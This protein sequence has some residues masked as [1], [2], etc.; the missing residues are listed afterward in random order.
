MRQHKPADAL[1]QFRI[2]LLAQQRA[3]RLL[4]NGPAR[5]E[6]KHGNQR[7]DPA[8]NPPVKEMPRQAA[9]QHRRG[10]DH[11]VPAVCGRGLQ[12]RGV[13]PFAQLSAK[14]AHP[15]LHK[16]GADED[17]EGQY[18]EFHRFGMENLLNGGFS[19]LH[20]DDQNQDC[21]KK[22]G[23]V[24]HSRMT[25]GMLRVCGTL[26]HFEAQQRDQRG[27]RIGEVVYGVGRNGDGAG[28]GARQQ[29]SRKKQE[30]ADDAHNPSQFPAGAPHRRILR[31]LII[32]DKQP[33]QELRHSRSLLSHLQFII[34]TFAAKVHL[35]FRCLFHVPKS[36]GRM[37]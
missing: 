4:C 14:Q 34:Q 7:A 23:E 6:D 18:G 10:C 13:N 3:D 17:A 28:E 20:A 12:R 33:Q 16:D 15:Q 8:V 1:H 37:I 30:I 36:C 22:A 11:V 21:H 25:I 2:G 31:V 26:R 32:L 24:F 9:Q 5:G 29:L 27:G 35:F 19:Q